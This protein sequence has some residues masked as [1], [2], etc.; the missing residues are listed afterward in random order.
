VYLGQGL[1]P[2]AKTRG[3]PPDPVDQASSYPQRFANSTEARIAIF[4]YIETFYNP[5]RLH[6][7]LGHLSPI[8]FES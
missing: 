5:R 8:N 1:L 6:S 2:A 7:S 3:Q 4:D